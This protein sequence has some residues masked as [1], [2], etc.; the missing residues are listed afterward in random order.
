M[1]STSL[2]RFELVCAT[3]IH[4]VSC[5]LGRLIDDRL[6][7]LTILPRDNEIRTGGRATSA[8]S[9]LSLLI[10]CQSHLQGNA[11]NGKCTLKL[12]NQ[13]TVK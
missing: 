9:L 4:R 1:E 3:P 11:R 13:L 12:Q 2:S 8:F 5:N 7:L 10:K 6:R